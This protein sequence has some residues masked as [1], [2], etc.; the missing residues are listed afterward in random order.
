MAEQAIVE[1]DQVSF[2]YGA[3][4]VLEKATVSIRSG[5]FVSVIG[6]N[7][8]GK[9]T[10]LR[11]M[12]GLIAPQTGTVRIFGDT[13]KRARQRIGYTPQYSKH[14]LDF[15]VSVMDVALM[16]CQEGNRF[17]R[18]GKTEKAAALRAL[19]EM[20][21]ADLA[22]RPY[23]DLS[24]GQRQR[25]LIA[26]ALAS[27]PELLLLDEPTSNVDAVVEDKLLD[28]L[29]QLNERMSII[30]VSHDLGFVSSVVE[31]VVCVNRNVV[32]HPTSELD[33]TVIQNIYG[34]DYRMVRHDHRCAEEGHAHD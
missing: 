1:F 30:M 2:S 25:V 4:P 11:L 19:E 12:L 6:P 20:E 7:G 16:G 18:Y 32:V 31:S 14:D 22:Q 28:L 5:E 13:P 29:K 21:L 15:P 10:L 17:G 33:G 26:R 9:T 23:S 34:G 8:G 24:G 27:D 3:I